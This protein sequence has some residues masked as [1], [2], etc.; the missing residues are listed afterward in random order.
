MWR[1]D[2]CDAAK[3]VRLAREA[4]AK[5]LDD[6]RR[7]GLLGDVPHAYDDKYLVT[8]SFTA[9]AIEAVGNALAALGADAAAV[10]QMRGWSGEGRRV[11]LRFS[12]EE[13]CVLLKKESAVLRKEE[14]VVQTQVAKVFSKIIDRQDVWKWRYSAAWE[15]VMY[16]GLD[17]HAE[18]AAVVLCHH[19]VDTFLKTLSSCP[20]RPARVVQ[21]PTEVDLSWWVKQGAG[22]GFRVARH[23][24]ACRTP[25]RNAEVAAAEQFFR[26]LTV[27]AEGVLDYW[28]DE[29][30]EVQG[31]SAKCVGDPVEP[32]YDHDAVHAGDVFVPILPLLE[33]VEVADGGADA[34]A[35]ACRPL[36]PDDTAAAL[37]EQARSLTSKRDAAKAA[38]ASATGLLTASE[39]D[40]S[41][42]LHHCSVVGEVYAKAVQYVED[43]LRKQLVAAVGK[44]ITPLDFAA[45]MTFHNRKVFSKEAQPRPFAHAIRSA[46]GG[47]PVGTLTLEAKTADG[48]VAPIA[49]FARQIPEDRCGPMRFALS[50]GMEAR[51]GGAR[52]VHGYVAHQFG[53]AGG[54]RLWLSAKAQS[55]SSYVVLLGEI[56]GAEAFVP[57][58]AILVRNRREFRIPLQCEALPA[59]K[60]FQDA[61]ESLSPEQ[62]AFAKAYRAMQLNATLFGV[63]VVHLAPQVEKVLNLPKDA[64]AQDVF[65]LDRIVNLMVKYS[66][67]SSLLAYQSDCVGDEDDGVAPAEKVARVQRN[68][69][70]MNVIIEDAKKKERE[71]KLAREYKASLQALGEFRCE[72]RKRG[73][74]F[75]RKSRKAS[76]SRSDAAP[77]AQAATG[78]GAP[79]QRQGS[80]SEDGAVDVSAIPH[81]LDARYLR[82]DTESCLRPTIIKAGDEW[83]VETPLLA[84]AWGPPQVSILDGDDQKQEK[85]KAFALLSAI[86]RCGAL[87]L[88]A[89]ELHVVIAAT[90]TFEKT[91]V[92]TVVQDNA[93]PIEKVERSVLITASTVLEQPVAQLLRPKQRR[94]VQGHAPHLFLTV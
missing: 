50:A 5:L 18:D 42:V 13:E 78:G 30:V 75:E 26:R 86:T 44:V 81:E 40:L 91:L 41:V 56:G 63:C 16:A 69:D 28:Y 88:D 66:I 79:Q 43:V 62:E 45:Y 90:H 6:T 32:M 3:R 89:A 51:F 70:A 21:D 14:H 38:F 64:L 68:V 52:W 49:T 24:P 60:A 15:V 33:A 20:P 92:D 76:R 77:Q 34:D 19:S 27:F 59:P 67:P 1:L 8:E 48:G 55:F 22:E 85:E 54:A 74:L 11:T 29:V 31:L 7:P 93:N 83:T 36:L 61:I 39:A 94:R 37:G 84:S 23:D 73:G 72:P 35:T 46:A 65:L 4:V 53:G 71:D 25:R 58:H 9:A 47:D 2:E 87:P 57:R 12:C 10:E 17:P 82:D 80:T